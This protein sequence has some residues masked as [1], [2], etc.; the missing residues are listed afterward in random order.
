MATLRKHI[1]SIS[2]RLERSTNLSNAVLR[3]EALSQLEP[4]SMQLRQMDAIEDPEEW[5]QLAASLREGVALLRGTLAAL[6]PERAAQPRPPVLM[7]EQSLQRSTIQSIALLG[8]VALGQFFWQGSAALVTAKSA[9]LC[10]CAAYMYAD[11][12]VWIY[13]VLLDR[14]ETLTLESSWLPQFVI[15]FLRVGSQGF[16]N[17]HVSPTEAFQGNDLSGLLD[18]I[19]LPTC[20]LA[21]AA[22]P[23]TSVHFKMW[24]VLLCVFLAVAIHNHLCC[25]AATHG[26]ENVPPFFT[27]SQSLGALP[28]PEHHRI[29]HQGSKRVGI[30]CSARAC[31]SNGVTSWPEACPIG[32]WCS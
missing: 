6:A 15:D 4:L 24:T 31:W 2:A 30:S 13:H 3:Q 29:H 26:A 25:H 11:L 17:H 7:I 21:L 27:L 22:S 28:W 9:G 8:A 20:W 5:V 16:H 23:W 32:C 14:D 19:L 12:A 18:P 10:V 1:E